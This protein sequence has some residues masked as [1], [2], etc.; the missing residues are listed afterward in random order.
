VDEGATAAWSKLN[1]KSSELIGKSCTRQYKT[2]PDIKKIVARS[3]LNTQ[4][5]TSML[6]LS[7][8]IYHQLTTHRLTATEQ[9]ELQNRME[10][11]QMKEFMNV[12][13]IIA[14]TFSPTHSL[15]ECSDVLEPRPELLRALRQQLR[16]QV[17]HLARRE[18]RHALRRQAHEGVAAVRRPL[19][20]AERCHGTTGRPSGQVIAPRRHDA[21][22]VRKPHSLRHICI[23]GAW[24][25]ACIFGKC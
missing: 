6:W 14:Y 11:K 9:R 1:G 10:K 5:W 25:R 7:S 13:Y 17:A 21:E 20:G 16:E 18:L 22:E 19:P 24:S 2:H 4:S 12:S 15:T 8:S 3:N 23:H